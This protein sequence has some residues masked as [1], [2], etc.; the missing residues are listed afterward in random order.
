MWGIWSH[1]YCI[2]EGYPE[3]GS[4][5][6]WPANTLQLSHFKRFIQMTKFICVYILNSLQTNKHVTWSQPLSHVTWYFKLCLR[7]CVCLCQS[8]PNLCNLCHSLVPRAEGRD[9]W[10]SCAP[11]PFL[12][13]TRNPVYHHGHYWYT[14]EA[15]S[16]YKLLIVASGHREGPPVTEYLPTYSAVPTRFRIFCPS[17]SWTESPKSAILMSREPFL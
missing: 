11:F 4:H 10:R 8:M 12:L 15:L 6:I 13:G 14:I 3:Q 2:H 9:K 1:P 17:L 5:K 16:C 7:V